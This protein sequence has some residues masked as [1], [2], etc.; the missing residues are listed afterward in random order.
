MDWGWAQDPPLPPTVT[1]QIR[2]WELEK[3]RVQSA[4]GYLYDDFRAAADFELVRD[5][6]RQLDCIVWEASPSLPAPTCWRVFVTDE[7]HAAIRFVFSYSMIP[8]SG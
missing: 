5:Y 3:N 1:D 6:A 8:Y 4:P 7:G 2:L